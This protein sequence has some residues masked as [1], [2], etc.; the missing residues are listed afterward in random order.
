VAKKTKFY[1]FKDAKMSKQAILAYYN[2]VE[3]YKRYGGSNNESNIR[4]AFAHLLEAYCNAKNLELIDELHLKGSQKRPD[5]TVKD[6]LDKEIKNKIKIYPTDNILFENSVS[7][8]LLQQGAETLRAVM[9]DVDKLH[10]VL[11]VFTAYERPEIRDFRMAITAFAQDI[12]LITNELKDL[13]VHQKNQNPRYQ[14]AFSD[15]WELCRKSIN[16]QI[17]EQSV[18][19]M[20]I[21]TF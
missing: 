13:M 14:L 11:T 17:S 9:S 5:G 8:V 2:K 3:R 16:P 4:R 10:H 19:E 18:Q 20:L 6:A 15:F 12:P 7:I 1:H 21:S